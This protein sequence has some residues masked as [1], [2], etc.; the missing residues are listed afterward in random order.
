MSNTPRKRWLALI[1][2]GLA[3]FLGCIDFTIV[4]TALP[5]IQADLHT[6]MNQLQWIITLF[7][8]AL[9]AFMVIAGRLADLFGRRL[10]L[11]IGMAGFGLTSLG[12]GLS[13]HI[14]L[15]LLFRFG[16]G[17]CTAILYTASGAIISN[18]FPE[19]E[20]GKALGTLF[21]I[22]G[23]GLAIGPVVGG[24]IIGALSWHWVFLVNVP[25]IILSFIICIPN[26]SE[27]KNTEQA[28]KIDW[29]GLLCLL[30]GLS[31]LIIALIQGPLWG[32]GSRSTLHL[33][34]VGIISLLL[35]YKIETT[36]QTPIIDFKL[37]MNRMF[38]G[39]I[40]ATFSLGF[41]YCLA[42][43]L[44]PLYLHNIQ[45]FSGYGLGLML[46][47]TTAVMALL[48]P[49]VGRAVDRF[50]P[51]PLLLLGAAFFILSAA[52]QLHFSANTTMLTIILT[53]A[54]MGV[55]WAAILGPS[56]VAVLSAVPESS[57]GLAMGTSWTLHNMG[58]IIG[59][60]IGTVTYHHLAVISLLK[61]KLIEG[62][63][64]STVWLNS[65]V[66]NPDHAL[67]LIQHHT[68][69]TQQQAQALFEQS[70]LSG[71]QGAMILLI[72]VMLL[73]FIMVMIL[74]KSKK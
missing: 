6:N 42:F 45:G 26:I 74:I 65:A 60:A 55:G 4:N 22:N 7:L 27:S 72:G 8:L 11:Y 31:I 61:Q 69:A 41:Y 21:S 14:D 2:I 12:A 67:A 3:S 13:T 15:L 50:G 9:C 18:A 40:I 28:A 30:V 71:Y 63:N 44:M 39:S 53:F 36:H 43:F 54:A 24:F 51:K 62:V 58:G 47:P 52:L 33:I 64:Q 56:T 34:I 38:F 1:G 68:D 17:L 10:V 29:G 73:S 48:S 25:L 46:L 19:E 59:L 37:F 66:S 16:Q 49:F 20:R 32:W 57:S 70:F 5:A 23:I 35:L